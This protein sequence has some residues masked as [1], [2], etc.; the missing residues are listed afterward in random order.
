MIIDDSSKV[1]QQDS[2][3]ELN[4]LPRVSVEADSDAS[5]ETL[6]DVDGQSKLPL[7]SVGVDVRPSQLSPLSELSSLPEGDEPMSS[8]FPADADGLDSR[9]G[10]NR[11][12]RKK[13]SVLV[14]F[15]ALA[16]AIGPNPLVVVSGPQPGS[17]HRASEAS[18]F[19]RE[20]FFYP[21]P[22]FPK[23]FAQQV[24]LDNPYTNEICLKESDVPIDINALGV[25][26]RIVNMMALLMLSPN[27]L[28]YR[29]HQR[30]C[31][32]ARRAGRP[33]GALPVGMLFPSQNTGDFATGINQVN[34]LIALF[35][36]CLG[37]R[38]KARQAA[39]RMRYRFGSF[40]RRG[41][42]SIASESRV[43]HQGGDLD[44]EATQMGMTGALEK[45]LAAGLVN[46]IARKQKE[47]TQKFRR[48]SSLGQKDKERGKWRKNE[49]RVASAWVERVLKEQRKVRR[50][51]QKEMEHCED[52]I[53]QDE[54][55]VP[56]AMTKVESERTESVLISLD[57]K[58]ETEVNGFSIESEAK[59]VMDTIEEQTKDETQ[60]I[61]LKESYI[62]SNQRDDP[63][64]EF[65]YCPKI[66]SPLRHSISIVTLPFGSVSESRLEG[67]ESQVSLSRS[68]SFGSS[69]S[70]EDD[71]LSSYGDEHE[72]DENENSSLTS[73][74]TSSSTS[75]TS[76]TSPETP[77]S[78]GSTTVFPRQHEQSWHTRHRVE[79]PV[80]KCASLS[81][82]EQS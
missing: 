28:G 76:P 50:E 44:T 69:F 78:P 41:V 51:R 60:V 48:R 57:L 14:S 43:P 46:R 56:S 61:E 17:K 26:K 12:E 64:K 13:G 27:C 19:F 70:Y 73:E 34:V 58:D 18:K 25:S 68:S 24:H 33:W 1:L 66:P 36:K 6:V 31:L 54:S 72:N 11:V 80:W 82:V 75:P 7:A 77:G 49:R 37:G 52:G 10:R 35:E 2:E 9:L 59:P 47:G 63:R 21:H 45:L 74:G 39:A 29:I 23:F 42:A 3:Q 62:P 15:S 65:K 81:R 79:L 5:D 22:A 38:I 67:D 20:I 30:Q 4:E 16:D 8:G 55:I 40:A 32:L 53:S 71:L